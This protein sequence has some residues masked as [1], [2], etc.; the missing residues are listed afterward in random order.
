MAG[1]DLA[2]HALRDLPPH[3]LQSERWKSLVYAPI[4]GERRT[5]G[6]VLLLHDSTYVPDSYDLPLRAALEDSRDA[7]QR[8]RHVRRMHRRQHEMAR[9]RRDESRFDRFKIAHFANENDIRI[10]T[11]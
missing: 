10:L 6:V 5:L 9:F 3:T 4:L 7:L 2:E 11:K 8:V 1:G